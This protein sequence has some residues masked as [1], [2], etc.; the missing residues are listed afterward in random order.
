MKNSIERVRMILMANKT[1]GLFYQIMRTSTTTMALVTT[2]MICSV[3]LASSDCTDC[4][5]TR[6]EGQEM[7]SSLKVPACRA[8]LSDGEEEDS[9]PVA[10]KG[11]TR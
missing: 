4:Q 3:G 8:L 2:W 1:V 9:Q 5:S 6:I 10:P 7:Q 11:G